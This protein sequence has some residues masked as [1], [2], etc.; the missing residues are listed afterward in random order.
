[1]FIFLPTLLRIL[2]NFSLKK[3]LLLASHLIFIFNASLI[4]P[5]LIRYIFVEKF[6]ELREPLDFIFHTCL[7][8]LSGVCSYP[9]AD[10]WLEEVGENFLIKICIFREKLLLRLVILMD[11]N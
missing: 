9:Q 6:I 1:M 11:F 8:Q 5:I 10:I 3:A 4:S 7:D 2:Q